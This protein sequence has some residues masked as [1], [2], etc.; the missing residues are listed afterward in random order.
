[1]KVFKTLERQKLQ[2]LFL[3]FVAGLSFWLSLT[4]L[5]PVLPSYI[6]AMSAGERSLTFALGSWNTSLLLSVQSQVGFVMGCFAIGLL[7][8]RSS[9]GQM[10]DRR[11]RKIVVLIGTIV[12]GIAPFGYLYFHS[13]PGLMA[14]RAFH[15]ISIAAF[16][17]GYSAWV[18]DLSPAKQR[19]ELISYMSLVIPVGMA[20]GPMVGGYVAETAGYTTVFV[21]SGIAGILAFVLA[22][23]VGETPKLETKV[24]RDSALRPKKLLQRLKHPALLTPTSVML[25][26]GLI[27]GTLISFLP[28]FIE[29]IQLDLNVGLFYA[30]AAI[31]SFISRVLTGRASD[32]YGRGI[33]ISGSLVCYGISMVLLS[34]AQSPQ[35]FLIAAFFEGAGAGTIVPMA[36]ALMSDRSAIDERGLVYS[37]CIGGFDLGMAIAGPILGF[38]AEPIGYRNLYFLSAILA[39]IALLVFISRINKDFLSSWR[40]ATGRG[41]DF[42]ALKT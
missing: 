1:M 38:L 3:L 21:L 35:A 15:G 39:A 33:F 22:S 9:L 6:K 18:V 11:G 25:C 28:L 13:I 26:V 30:V 27:F 24:A 42:Y 31:A 29:E 5:L 4:A 14:L 8:F 23:Q 37:I 20:L 40:F 36:I 16:T 7:M 32:R 10:A 41:Q 17:T 2:N 12:S 34:Y 19:G